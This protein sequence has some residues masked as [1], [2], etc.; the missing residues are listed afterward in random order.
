MARH[1][2][3]HGEIQVTPKT[4]VMV[5]ESDREAAEMQTARAKIEDKRANGC[6]ADKIIDEIYNARVSIHNWTC[7][8]LEINPGK[9][10]TKLI[11]DRFYPMLHLA[12]DFFRDEAERA[13]GFVEDKRKILNAKKIL[14]VSVIFTDGDLDKAI[15]KAELAQGISIRG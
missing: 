5:T 9:Y 11:V 13:A 2:L 3:R 14:Y 6:P 10:R 1:T 7:P 15:A 8:E 4:P 12:I